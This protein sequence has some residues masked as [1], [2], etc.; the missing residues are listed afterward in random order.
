MLYR[1]LAVARFPPAIAAFPLRKASLSVVLLTRA[2]LGQ[3]P[4]S[5]HSLDTLTPSMNIS[6]S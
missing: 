6:V 2:L 4:L 1:A 5:A 3:K